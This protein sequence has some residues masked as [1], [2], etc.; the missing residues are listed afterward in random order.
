[1]NCLAFSLLFRLQ[2]LEC[3]IVLSVKRHRCNFNPHLMCAF[4]R[5]HDDFLSA[6]G[7][8]GKQ[9]SQRVSPTD[10][11]QIFVVNTLKH[12]A[13][14]HMLFYS[15]HVCVFISSIQSPHILK[16]SLQGLQ[17]NTLAFIRHLY[18]NGNV[19]CWSW[20]SVYS[21]AVLLFKLVNILVNL[22]VFHLWI[23]TL[24]HPERA[25]LWSVLSQFPCGH[26]SSTQKY[27]KA[28]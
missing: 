1:M 10:W 12:N 27:T 17:G 15:R 23:C 22:I 9:R 4:V 11:L 21:S 2:W 24:P 26:S 18:N 8:R 19:T 13:H 20:G 14:A 3:G 28:A 16:W 25:R 5:Y 6:H 7:D